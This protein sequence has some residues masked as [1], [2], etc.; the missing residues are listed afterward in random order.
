[1]KPWG[2]IVRKRL[3]ENQECNPLGQPQAVRHGD[4]EGSF[5]QQ[6]RGAGL[7]IKTENTARE[8]HCSQ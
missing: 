4:A 6:N 1:M 2:R 8:L 7:L 5:E 3:T